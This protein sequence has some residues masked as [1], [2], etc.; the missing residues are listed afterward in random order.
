MQGLSPIFIIEEE[1]KLILRAIN[2]LEDASKVIIRSTVPKEFWE[3][4]ISFFNSFYLDNHLVKEENMLIPEF[5]RYNLNAKQWSET[6]IEEHNLSKELLKDIEE[7]SKKL[8]EDIEA[9]LK[10]IKS[11]KLFSDLIRKHISQESSMLPKLAM[12]FPRGL[13]ERLYRRFAAMGDL[14]PYKKQI[15]DLENKS[16]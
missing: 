8:G 4:I 5:I 13:M 16:G 15:E 12:P 6:I 10:L 7:H 2:L 9:P 3:K 11:I 14:E 1:H